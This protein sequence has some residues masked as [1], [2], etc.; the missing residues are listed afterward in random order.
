LDCWRFGGPQSDGRG[1]NPDIESELRVA[2]LYQ[3]CDWGKAIFS[4]EGLLD[5]IG[6]CAVREDFLS[7]FLR[8]SVPLWFLF[9]FYLSL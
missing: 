5:V 2:Y 6:K 7:S 3:D 1:G 9:S 4:R 8:V